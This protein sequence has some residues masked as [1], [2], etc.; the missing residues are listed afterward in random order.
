MNSMFLSAQKKLSSKTQEMEE[1][2]QH[3]RS[4]LQKNEK[5]VSG[6]LPLCL[7]IHMIERQSYDTS[8]TAVF[9]QNHTEV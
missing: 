8:K 2:K 6:S 3:V 4:T 7:K 5:N 9:Q 1:S